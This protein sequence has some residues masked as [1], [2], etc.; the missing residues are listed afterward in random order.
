MSTGPY[1]TIQDKSFVVYVTMTD[2]EKM[3]DQDWANVC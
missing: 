3:D 1:D 2:L